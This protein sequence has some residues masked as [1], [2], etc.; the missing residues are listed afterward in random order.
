MVGCLGNQEQREN[1]SARGP[2]P[3]VMC[4][5][6][7][8]GGGDPG[9]PLSSPEICEGN[10]GSGRKLP[11]GLP[12]DCGMPPSPTLRPRALVCARPARRQAG[13]DATSVT[14][15]G[16][17]YGFWELGRFAVEYQRLFGE[18][19]SATLHRLPR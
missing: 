13:R 14:A 6:Y 8:W 1:G 4:R 16:T 15:I 2:N 12:E 7:D 17:L 18:A 3:V 5:G 11:T 19:P 10:R 9:A